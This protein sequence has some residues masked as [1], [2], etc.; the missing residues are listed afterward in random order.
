MRLVGAYVGALRTANGLTQPE[1]AEKVGISEKTVRN[2]ESGRHEPKTTVLDTILDLLHG[3][4]AHVAQ[5]LRPGANRDLAER[6]AKEAIGGES[7]TDEQRV[8]LEGLT[9]DQKDA[10]LRVARQMQQ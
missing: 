1:L 10:I 3:S 9:P 8:F 4:W 7:F 5:L 6:L 2:I